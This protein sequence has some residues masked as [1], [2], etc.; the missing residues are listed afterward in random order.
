MLTLR[1]RRPAPW[2]L[3]AL[4]ASVLCACA[5]PRTLQA[6]A[7]IGD[8]G[9]TAF[10]AVQAE[11]VA[12]MTTLPDVPGLSR[13][14]FEGYDAVQLETPQGTA[15]I[16]L[17]GGHL[18]SYV[19]HGG[20]EV[21][22]L[23]PLSPRPPAP[24]RGGVPVLWPYF[25]RQGQRA[26]MPAHGLVRTLPWRVVS[27]ERAADGAL[28]VVMAPPAL[29]GLGLSLQMTVQLGKT[30]EQTLLT[31]N[32]GT[33]PV[34]FTQALHTYYRVGD[35]LQ[36]RVRGLDG[37]TY[38]EK[39]E[40][41]AN[42]YRQRGDWSLADI[43]GQADRLYT[44]TAGDYTIDDPILHRRIHLRTEGSNSVVTWN[45]GIAVETRS[46]DIGPGWRHYV[47]LEATNAG[48]DVVELVPGAQHRLV[49]RI[50]VD[51]A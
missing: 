15:V 10:A 17:F 22:W 42:A 48:A 1:H 44:G 31:T 25:A 49:Q 9:E 36:V 20:Q 40:G 11:P 39:S 38:R 46:P 12:A 4:L 35:A 5:A 47:C 21:L 3:G 27:A 41:F 32:T 7:G 45:P 19:P 50:R 28:S 18:L 13:V 23:S 34:R 2:W 33:T 29:P 14:Q 8:V 16:A 37:A 51:P 6:P 30:L 43:G 24:V 26:D